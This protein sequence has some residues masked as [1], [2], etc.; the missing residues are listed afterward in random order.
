MLK[1]LDKDMLPL[2]YE[3]LLAIFP[4][5]E[6]KP[7]GWLSRMLDSSEYAMYG[8]YI[9]DRLSGI[10]LL[11]IK[12]EPALLDYFA[13]KSDLR[14]K[15]IG[16]AFLSALQE[17]PL[18]K[19][20]LIIE[21]ESINHAKDERAKDIRTRRIAFYK[22]LLFREL[23]F[24]PTIFGTTFSILVSKKVSLNEAELKACYKEI[25]Q[26]MVPDAFHHHLDI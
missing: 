13:I 10:A 15:G 17:E 20:G 14:A 12:S 26:T 11:Y 23:D 8:Y 25:Y 21:A 18:F 16:S 6:V 3:W 19:K 24:T 22:R 5:E 9:E 2:V 4:K 1:R 7:I